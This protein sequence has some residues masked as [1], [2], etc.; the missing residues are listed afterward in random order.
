MTCVT[1]CCRQQT[2]TTE[3]RPPLYDCC[4]RLLL[5]V[6]YCT[7]WKHDV[8]S[9][10]RS[11]SRNGV[12]LL[13]RSDAPITSAWIILVLDI[14]MTK[15]IQLVPQTQVPFFI[16]LAS[17][18]LKQFKTSRRENLQ[19]QFQFPFH[20]QQMVKLCCSDGIFFG[21]RHIGFSR[22]T[23]NDKRDCM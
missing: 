21:C 22:Q 4:I 6:L 8:W 23:M 5:N 1:R 15:L 12:A 20:Q 11:T 9:T 10:D 13:A 2:R 18:S 19:C 7:A 3:W 16:M 17:G 14:K